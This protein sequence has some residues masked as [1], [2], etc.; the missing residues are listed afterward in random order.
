[1]LGYLEQ[2]MTGS[3]REFLYFHYFSILFDKKHLIYIIYKLLIHNTL[4][5]FLL[6][7]QSGSS[8]SFVYKLLQL[9]YDNPADLARFLID[10]LETK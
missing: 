4:V 7:F 9:R 3:F 1:M 8:F 2:R 5:Y 10:S 6:S